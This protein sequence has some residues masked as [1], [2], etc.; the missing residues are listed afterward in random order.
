M[1]W[2]R[3]IAEISNGTETGHTY[4]L[5]GFWPSQAAYDAAPARFLTDDPDF[6]KHPELVEEFHMQLTSTIERHVEN[7]VHEW[8]VV[9][10]GFVE[11]WEEV[12]GEWQTKDLN[13]EM[14]TVSRPLR[15]LMNR[16]IHAYAINAELNKWSGDHTADE[17]KG[18]FKDGV[19][20][21]QRRNSRRTARDLSDPHG[22][23]AHTDTAALRQS[24]EEVRNE[25]D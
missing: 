11:P 18:L 7:P 24:R 10:G 5:V 1:V 2:I 25:R 4:V 22:V 14:V 17:R 20:V 21:P 9:G 3:E 13:W 12:G 19:R 15:R 16:N 8:K 6:T 23:L